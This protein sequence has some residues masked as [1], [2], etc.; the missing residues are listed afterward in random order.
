MESIRSF[1]AFICAVGILPDIIIPQKVHIQKSAIYAGRNCSYENAS[2][3]GQGMILS[4][5]S[6]A[7]EFLE[8][9]RY[10]FL[11]V[12][13]ETGFVTVIPKTSRT[14]SRHVYRNTAKKS[15]WTPLH[16]S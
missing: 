10:E 15:L 11:I 8:L 3:Q 9:S 6:L 4:L 2:S 12:N 7:C 5:W 13:L 1:F 16:S 14:S